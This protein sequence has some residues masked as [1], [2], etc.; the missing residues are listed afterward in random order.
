MSDPSMFTP[1]ELENWKAIQDF[2]EE[3]PEYSKIHDILIEE[4]Y[5]FEPESFKQV[6]N[7]HERIYDPEKAQEYISLLT[8][9]GAVPQTHI[10]TEDKE[11]V[12]TA[13]RGLITVSPIDPDKLPYRTDVD[14]KKY[15]GQ[16]YELIE[17]IADQRANNDIA[18]FKATGYEFTKF[19]EDDLWLKRKMERMTFFMAYAS[20][21]EVRGENLEEVTRSSNYEEWA[22]NMDSLEVLLRRRF[23]GPLKRIPMMTRWGSNTQRKW[24]C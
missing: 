3:D 11:K 20:D 2:N 1:D 4:G 6:M 18:E 21:W 9:T 17:D 8:N 13:L 12:E 19:Q 24:S 22:R 7:T 15:W 14:L 5:R 23:K 16:Y 10:L